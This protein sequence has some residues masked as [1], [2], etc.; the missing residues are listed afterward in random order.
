M[1]SRVARGANGTGV[2]VSFVASAGDRARCLSHIE[3]GSGLF[4]A[5]GAE[6][7]EL[8]FIG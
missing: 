2:V 7:G 3:A 5:G 8:D 4:Q 1:V 6:Q